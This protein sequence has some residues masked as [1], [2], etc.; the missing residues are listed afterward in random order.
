[1]KKLRIILGSI[2]IIGGIGGIT[3]GDIIPAIFCILCGIS[4][5]PAIYEKSKLKDKKLVQIIIPIILFSICGMTLQKEN[6]KT[7]YPQ[8]EIYTNTKIEE[9][10]EIEKL[11]FDES[12][13]EIDIKETKDILLNIDPTTADISEIKF[14]STNSQIVEFNKNTEKSNEKFIYAKIQPIAEGE[15]EVYVSSNEIESNRIKI[16]IIDKERIE[17]E[18]KLEEERIQREAEEAAAAEQAKKLAEEQ[19]RKKEEAA[20]AE[21]ARQQAQRQAQQQ[22]TIKKQTN[23]STTTQNTNNSRT[24]YR[25]PTGKRYHYISTCGGKNS[26][27]TTLSQAIAS[28]LTPCQKCAQ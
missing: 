5:I 28:G 7:N 2:I 20:A 8:N 4:L 17:K 16:T 19:E 25:T 10:I 14:N 24:V 3:S 11:K 21:Q 27:A 23:Q 6:V 1:M 18:K 9:K 22:Q 13:I 15:A 26:T 12:D